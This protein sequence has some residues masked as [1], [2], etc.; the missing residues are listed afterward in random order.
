MRSL[1]FDMR[2]YQP[3]LETPFNY[4][5]FFNYMRLV[6]PEIL[7]PKSAKTSAAVKHLL[8]ITRQFYEDNASQHNT[9]LFSMGGCVYIFDFIVVVCILLV[10]E[11]IFT[12]LSVCIRG[13]RDIDFQIVRYAPSDVIVHETKHKLFASIVHT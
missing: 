9:L 3:N 10:Y 2:F 8:N 12:N 11:I 5:V 7:N 1:V 6:Y 4:P 13:S